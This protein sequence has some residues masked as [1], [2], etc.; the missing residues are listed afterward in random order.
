MSDIFQISKQ[1]IGIIASRARKVGEKVPRATG[2]RGDTPALEASCRQKCGCSSHK[3]SVTTASRSCTIHCV[4]H[5]RG[6]RLPLPSCRIYVYHSTW[7]LCFVVDFVHPT[8]HQAI[9]FSWPP[10]IDS[11]R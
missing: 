5:A 10:E 2:N 1:T 6:Q 4:Y 7:S 9:R 8:T 3:C 11:D